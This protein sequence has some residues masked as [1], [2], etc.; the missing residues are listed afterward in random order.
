M[1]YSEI[2]QSLC[3]E[4]DGWRASVSEDWLQG[5][6]LFGGL[7]AAL[8]L[9]A[10]RKQ[11]P[12]DLPLRT[13]QVTFLA[14]VPAGTVPIRARVLR[15]GK[16]TLHVE[17]RLVQGDQTLCL[18]IGIFGADRAS[19]V[20]RIP[21]QPPCEPDRPADS[22][23]RP[24]GIPAFTQH[25][26]ARWLR[27]GP[28][29]SGNRSP[30]AVLLVGLRDTGPVT[31]AHVPALADFIPP[32]G[33]SWFTVPTPGSSM[34]WMLEFLFHDFA[35]LPLTGWRVDAQLVAAGNGYQSQSAT[36]WGPGG[37]PVALSS[38]SMV[39]FG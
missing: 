3:P 32:L 19:T 10:M 18:G 37:V 25:F 20:R 21:E 4:P 31:E 13:L 29:F 17:G 9:L 11:V 6:S 26:K 23:Y 39:V 36:L 5:R 30:E 35:R 27:G 15:A 24:D 34:T 14:P 38:Q 16:N 33:L 1:L 28:P 22:H 2:L 8:M 12:A 7:Q